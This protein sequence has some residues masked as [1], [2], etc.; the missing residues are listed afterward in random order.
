MK[1]RVEEERDDYYGKYKKQINI[2]VGEDLYKR[3]KITCAE[4]DCSM[5]GLLTHYIIQ[6]LDEKEGIHRGN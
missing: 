4:Q 1:L 2:A 6:F 5:T 3:F